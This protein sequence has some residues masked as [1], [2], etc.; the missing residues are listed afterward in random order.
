MLASNPKIWGP[1]L[2]CLLHGSAIKYKFT[3]KNYMKYRLFLLTLK[4]VIPCNICKHHFN[5]ELSRISFKKLLKTNKSLNTWL[6]KFHD[7]VNKNKKIYFMERRTRSPSYKASRIH[8]IKQSEIT[9][10]YCLWFFLKIISITENK[11]DVIAFIKAT[12]NIFYNRRFVKCMSGCKNIES[13]SNS[14]NLSYWLY[15]VEKYLKNKKTTRR[16]DIAFFNLW[17]E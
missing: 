15:R 12:N 4:N 9:I 3:D 5:I 11:Q 8:W 10:D 1:F 14:N 6:Y 7:Y 13:I 2:W 17:V 16:T